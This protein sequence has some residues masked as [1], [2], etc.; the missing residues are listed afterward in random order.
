MHTVDTESPCCQCSNRVRLSTLMY[1]SMHLFLQYLT[2][3]NN[4]ITAKQPT[5]QHNQ[6]IL[7]KLLDPTLNKSSTYHIQPYHQ[8]LKNPTTAAMEFIV[9]KIENNL[10]KSGMEDR[11][12]LKSAGSRR[13]RS[14]NSKQNYISIKVTEVTE[15]EPVAVIPSPSPSPVRSPAVIMAPLTPV[16]SDAASSIYSRKASSFRD[17]LNKKP[18]STTSSTS[19][20]R[21][22]REFM[23]A[24]NSYPWVS[25]PSSGLT[26]SA[27]S[28]ASSSRREAPRKVSA[29]GFPCI[30]ACV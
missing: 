11:Q 27:A 2:S 17:F 8:N 29:F 28:T 18:K 21:S 16:T 1:K 6:Q 19:S 24:M 13:G 5:E 9:R 23:S 12:S 14:L 26:S 30:A 15:V 3:S 10:N 7:P 20:K 4:T 22:T 25:G